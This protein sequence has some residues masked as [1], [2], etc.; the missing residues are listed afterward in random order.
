M[1]RGQETLSGVLHAAP[2]LGRA[3]NVREEGLSLCARLPAGC[4]AKTSTGRR[5][6]PKIRRPIAFTNARVGVQT[7]CR[8]AFRGLFAYDA[9]GTK[10]AMR[11][12][13]AS[14]RISPY[15]HDPFKQIPDSSSDSVYILNPIRVLSRICCKSTRPRTEFSAPRG[16]SGPRIGDI[17][18][19][20]TATLPHFVLRSARVVPEK[21]STRTPIARTHYPPHHAHRSASAV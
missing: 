17:H 19:E 7:R 12:F 11:A 14:N 10:P 2:C 20:Q 9:S 21:S 13:Q 4:V 5:L 18:A 3:L 6:C 1:E 8:R 16:G 15:L